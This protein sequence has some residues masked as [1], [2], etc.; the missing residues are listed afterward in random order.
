VYKPRMPTYLGLRG[1]KSKRLM[2]RKEEAVT[3]VGAC[4]S[5]EVIRLVVEVL[6]G[7]GADDVGSA[8]RAPVFFRRSSR[9]RCL[10]CQ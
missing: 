7:L 1:Q 9:R 4:L 8:H 5:C 3:E 6:V 10:S 2:G